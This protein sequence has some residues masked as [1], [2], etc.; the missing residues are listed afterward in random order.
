M[1]ATKVSRTAHGPAITPP[2]SG[3]CELLKNIS[4][5]K[6]FSSFSLSIK[7]RGVGFESL[8]RD[9]LVT[10]DVH[11]RPTENDIPRGELQLGA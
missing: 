7:G 6:F 5:Y 1:T 10:F 11:I 9:M 3:Y 2:L 8:F 4:H